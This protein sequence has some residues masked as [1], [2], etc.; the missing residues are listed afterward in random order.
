MNFIR[1]NFFFLHKNLCTKMQIM[2]VSRTPFHPP[3]LFCK[4]SQSAVSTVNINSATTVSLIFPPPIDK[5][6]SA[7]HAKGTKAVN[8]EELTKTYTGQVKCC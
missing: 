1:L 6:T 2:S 8:K 7:S 5:K 3:N 4:Q